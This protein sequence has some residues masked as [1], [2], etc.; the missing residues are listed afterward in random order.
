MFA[1]WHSR[2]LSKKINNAHKTR[3]KKG[4]VVT[5]GK[6]W[7]YDQVNADLVINERE[8]EVVKL[9]FDL[10]IQ[11]KGFR[12]IVQ[13]LTVRGITNQNGNPFALTTLQR[14]IRNEKYKGQLICGKRHKNFFTKK[15]ENVPESEWVI[16]ENRIPA[17][18]EPHIWDKANEIL[19]GKRK[20]LN[21]DDRLKV[22]GYF[23]GSYSLSGK[24]KCALCD[25]PY[26]HSSYTRKA[27]GV[28]VYQWQCY[29]YKSFGK[30]HPNGC[31]NSTLR[32]DDLNHVVRE[33][34]FDF[35][36]N[37]EQTFDNLLGVLGSSL[38][39]NLHLRDTKKLEQEKD[40]I[41]ARLSKLIALFSDELISKQ[42]FIE[43]REAL[44][45]D[46]HDVECKLQKISDNTKGT[47]SKK[48]RLSG[49]KEFFDVRFADASG[50][51]DEFLKDHV[52]SI[53]VH[54]NYNLDITIGGRKY[55][56]VSD[57]RPD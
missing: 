2:N 53:L 35:W 7:G 12:T 30:N 55:P 32:E 46:L 49:I 19:Q 38:T 16:H 41:K 14:M 29:A 6:L 22:A 51:S 56:N 4:T 31:C 1:E 13:D 36:D 8:A 20:V 57:V 17:I 11:G 26:Y 15:T 54:P 23:N 50:I 5:N 10:Y 42:E 18:I 39:D 34:I 47:T 28:K 33:V 27:S 3:M 37:K 48:D 24:L 44:H 40:R 45:K 9:V 21:V 43:A 25:S 52:D